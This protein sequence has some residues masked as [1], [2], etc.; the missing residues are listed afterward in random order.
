MIKNL[1]ILL[2]KKSIHKYF[3]YLFVFFIIILFSYFFIPK[4][5]NYSPQLVEE[6]LRTNNDINIKNI[7]KIT[8]KA[9]PT[10]RLKVSG[11]NFYV[12]GFG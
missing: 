9:F 2:K 6:S 3:F 8:Y 7:S 4:F 11:S 5:L 10:P 1:N 12:K